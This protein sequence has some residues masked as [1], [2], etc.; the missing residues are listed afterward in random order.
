[1]AQRVNFLDS[2]PYALTYRNIMIVLGAWVGLCV[3][4]EAGL[5]GYAWLVEKR[6]E[7]MQEQV[8][9]LQ[10]QQEQQIQLLA[11]SKTQEQTGTAIQSLT[12][13]FL[14][15]PRWSA[16]LHALLKARPAQV[17][18]VRF[19]SSQTEGAAARTVQLEGY[20]SNAEAMAEFVDHLSHVPM[21]KHVVLVESSREEKG[22]G[23]LKFLINATLDFTPEG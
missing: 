17:D 22:D 23:R 2:G 21:Y 4:V 15:P 14:N 5:I 8:K 12:T 18:L 10:K 11:L 7:T 19:A 1:M 13:R 3:V 9:L 20:S 16:V 6:L